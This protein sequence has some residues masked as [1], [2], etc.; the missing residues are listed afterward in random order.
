MRVNAQETVQEFYVELLSPVCQ[1]R[2]P[3][4]RVDK[5]VS[6][7]NSGFDSKWPEVLLVWQTN[8]NDHRSLNVIDVAP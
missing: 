7:V 2:N 6:G 1:W 8:V 4:L 5:T 3:S